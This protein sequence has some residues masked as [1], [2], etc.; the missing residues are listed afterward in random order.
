MT[1]SLFLLKRFVEH[2]FIYPFILVGRL[3]AYLNPLEK[4]YRVF[5]FF[6][7]YHTGGAEKVHAQIAEATGGNDCIIYFTRTSLNDRFLEEFK[8][9]GCQI[10]DI[11]KFTD[12]KWLFPFNLIYRGIISG[13]IN[14]QSRRSI[15]FNGQSNFGYKISPW[16]NKKVAQVELIHALNTFSLIRMP[17]L[18]YYKKKVTVSQEIFDKHA[19]LYKRYQV[20]EKAFENFIW[21][22]SKID[23]PEKKISKDYFSKP[24]YL[25][26]VGRDSIEKRPA[27]VAQ[28]AKNVKLAGINAI[29]EFAG[30]VSKSIPN[31]L[32]AYCKFHGDIND[33]ELNLLYCKAHILI[34]PSATESGPLVLMEAMAHGAAIISTDVGYVPTFVKDGVSGFIIKNILQ[35]T[36]IIV[37]ITQKVMKLEGDRNLLKKMG[38]KNIEI[39]FENFGIQ[40]F[41]K[42]YQQLF[43]SILN[44]ETS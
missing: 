12:N 1:Y 34:I 24:L 11:S 38:E 29:V 28:V 30:D 8:T 32:H 20:P 22:R 16:I 36:K 19:Q 26:F 3:I 31:E 15:V 7:F 18:E 2:I 41:R 35:E 23:L 27:I 14:H 5:Y 9:T 21:I 44:N 40:Q 43:E 6:P 37:E 25:L 13:H 4:E 39:A 42:E 17:Y 10:N 33:E